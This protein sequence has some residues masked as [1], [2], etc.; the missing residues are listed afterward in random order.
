MNIQNNNLR[1]QLAS[2]YVLGTLMG[3][4][5]R[6]FEFYMQQDPSLQILVQRWGQVLHPMGSMVKE[7]KP[8]KRVWKSIEQRLH[9]NKGKT[10]FWYNLLFWR[11]L[12]LLSATAAIIIGL[13]LGPFTLLPKDDLTSNYLA[14]IE[15]SHSQGTWLVSTDISKKSLKVRNL[16]VQQLA[17]NKDFEL[18]LLPASDGRNSFKAPISVGLISANKQ[19]DIKLSEKLVMA[20]KQAGG[21][22]VSLE[23]KGGSTTGLPTGPV[24]YQG[25]L[26][27][28]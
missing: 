3:A 15:N 5:R 13:Y 4:A 1:N 9:L 12:S 27:V 7:V 8:P 23:P 14:L 28:L 10:G 2:E 6:R 24:L 18:W 21:V 11:S 25:K 17:D 19:S 22:A 16:K 26:R 20:L